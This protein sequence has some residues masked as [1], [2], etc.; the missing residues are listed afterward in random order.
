MVPAALRTRT[1]VREMAPVGVEVAVRD[2]KRSGDR[3]RSYRDRKPGKALH[4]RGALYRNRYIPDM[5]NLELVR[6]SSFCG[7]STRET[8]RLRR[9]RAL[10]PSARGATSNATSSVRPPGKPRILHSRICRRA[11]ACNGSKLLS[12]LFWTYR[13]TKEQR[14]CP[15]FVRCKI[16][17]LRCK[18]CNVKDTGRTKIYELQA[19][20]GRSSDTL[21]ST[22]LQ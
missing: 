15:T 11:G 2:P 9:P 3:D 8:P 7:A 14:V 6:A 20:Q 19:F 22:S 13:L 10:W 18:P 1:D 21:K 4:Q 5:N 17:R 12:G 16:L